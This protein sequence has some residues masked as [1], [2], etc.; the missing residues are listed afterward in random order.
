[1]RQ[2]DV[3]AATRA[4]LANPLTAEGGMTGL[5]HFDAKGRRIWSMS[6]PSR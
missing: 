5:T 3:A 6:R 2:A 1:M 4:I